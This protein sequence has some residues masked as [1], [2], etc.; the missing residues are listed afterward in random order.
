MRTPH[1]TAAVPEQGMPTPPPADAASTGGVRRRH[2][3][4]SNLTPAEQLRAA[5][6]TPDELFIRDADSLQ[7]LTVDSQRAVVLI[8]SRMGQYVALDAVAREVGVGARQLTRLFHQDRNVR[9]RTELR[10]P[11]LHED[12]ARFLRVQNLRR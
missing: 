4:L 1:P 5:G 2:R 10:A 12:Q 9:T 11:L 3:T 7:P 6:F 8:E